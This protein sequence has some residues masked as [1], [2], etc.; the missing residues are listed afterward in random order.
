MKKEHIN[1]YNAE[2]KGRWA[3]FLS[4]PFIYAMVIP[5]FIIH[6]CT[7]IY[8]A[9]CFPLYGIKTID[10]N[11]YIR[12]QR[13][14]LQYLSW[15]EKLNCLYCGY[16]NGVIEFV[17]EVAN[18][19]ERAWCPIKDKI[20]QEAIELHHREAFAGYGDEAELEEYFDKKRNS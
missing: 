19:T 2:Q 6:V 10:S 9:I 18:E 8:Q 20:P 4:M 5:F 12:D 13:W 14:K 16:A 3:L 15:S 11:K 17:K 7:E 1:S